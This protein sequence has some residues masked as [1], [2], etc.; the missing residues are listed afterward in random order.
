MQVTGN[1]YVLDPLSI[2]HTA[3]DEMSMLQFGKENL[4]A[5]NNNANNGSNAANNRLDDNDSGMDK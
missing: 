5:A 3:G 1:R 2:E 4:M